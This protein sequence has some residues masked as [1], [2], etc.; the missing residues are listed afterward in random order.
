LT[1]QFPTLT[2]HSANIEISF[3]DPTG[4]KL[5]HK[6]EETLKQGF[7]FE[8]TQE[9]GFYEI[10]VLVNPKTSHPLPTEF[11]IFN[12]FKLK[13]TPFLKLWSTNNKI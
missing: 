9:H 13:R 7:V 2:E 3:I 10:C 6:L 5:E 1:Y 4:K 11:V 8:A 12:I